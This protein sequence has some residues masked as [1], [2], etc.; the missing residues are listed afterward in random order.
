MNHLAHAYL[1]FGNPDI[2]VGNMISDFVKGK[3]K[4]SYPEGI[5]KGIRLHR[6]IDTFTDD[7]PATRDAKTVFK[8]D[9]RLYSGAFVDI[10]YDHFL[11]IDPEEFSDNTLLA[12]SEKVFE[13]LEPY[14]SMFP[15]PFN[16]MFPHMKQHNW[17][18]NYQYRIGIERS[19]G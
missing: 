18:Y 7:H 9:Y 1:S 15:E 16:M 13:Q 14:A 11:A 17:L 19:F 12:F 6:A 3:K 5:R 10:V 4:D 8:K 2:L